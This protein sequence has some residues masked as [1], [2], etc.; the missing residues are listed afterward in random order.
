MDSVVS[1]LCLQ[2]LVGDKIVGT[3]GDLKKVVHLQTGQPPEEQVLVFFG[4]E[5]E[6]ERMLSSYP[7]KSTSSIILL[8]KL[9]SSSAGDVE[10]DLVFCV[11]CTGSMGGYIKTAQENITNIVE[12]I[13]A[14]ES[15]DIRFALVMYRDHPPQDSTYV[16]QIREFTSDIT[17]MRHYVNEM[18][19][20][21]GGDTPEAMTSG[22]FQSLSLPYR[23]TATKVCVLIADAPPHGL[24][25]SGDGF[26]NGDPNTED[27]LSI[28]RQ[29][30]TRGIRVYCV[31][32]EPSISSY[33]EATSW[34]KWTAELCS[35]RYVSLQ[36]ANFLSNIII[37]GCREELNLDKLAKEVIVEKNK[38][39]KEGFIFEEDIDSRKKAASLI[40]SQLN[41]RK[42]T[43]VELQFHELPNSNAFKFYN[44]FNDAQN[45]S[46]V[47]ALIAANKFE[48][49][50]DPK[51]KLGITNES[52][53][54]LV[55][56]VSI[57]MEH[58]MK[59]FDR[60]SK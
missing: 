30:A 27:L 45:L 23:D 44:V 31:G 33:V 39:S 56:T 49:Y 18:Q 35:G 43:T 14:S 1:R 12:S 53:G 28:S 57:T 17:I 10:L 15:A 50:L 46:D 5:M 37:G 32:C 38:M 41:D 54:V 36:R 7:L 22:L 47:K 26:P 21:G 58:V 11:D 9:E 3:V 8:P 59:I 19:A 24:S 55:L 13:I 51:Q 4:Q 6:D 48:P 60:I 42:Q 40:A 16:T 34:M 20:A 2:T 29:L 52:D 25:G